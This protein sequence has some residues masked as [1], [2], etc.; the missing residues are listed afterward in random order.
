MFERYTERAR[1]VVFFARYEASMY[2]SSYIETE[3]FLLGLL[4][5]D[6]NVAKLLPEMKPLDEIRQ[7]IERHIERH[8]RIP[9]SVEVPLTA[10]CKRIL[11]F[12]A[13]EAERLGHRHVGTEHLLLGLLREK[14]GLGAAILRADKVN[15]SKLRE[16]LCGSYYTGSISPSAPTERKLV[17]ERFLA[18]LRDGTLNDLHDFFT[19]DSWFIDASGKLWR[20]QNE[21]VPNL[22]ILLAPFAKRNAKPADETHTSTSATVLVATLIWEDVHIPGFSPL[23]L[24]RMSIVFGS[25][26]DI[27][28]VYL[29]QITPIGSEALGK[30]A[31]T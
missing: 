25:E 31:T 5:E 3:H 20:G 10:Q 22:E 19:A 30:I 21:I 11:T 8:E 6:P 15:L 29:I 1:R 23:D 12:A 14:G 17:V 24:F 16:K 13:E 9:T 2:G 28:I 18:A 7:E 4:R 27:P 26:E